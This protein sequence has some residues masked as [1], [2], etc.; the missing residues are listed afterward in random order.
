MN[1]VSKVAVLVCAVTL[2]VSP[3]WTQPSPPLSDEEIWAR[4]E[5]LQKELDELKALVNQRAASPI[6]KPAAPSPSPITVAAPSKFRFSGYLQARAFDDQTT[7]NAPKRTDQFNVRRVRLEFAGDLSQNVGGRLT[8]DVGGSTGVGSLRDAYVDVKTK[9]ATF[10]VGQWKFPFNYEMALSESEQMALEASLATQRLFPG[11]RERGAMVDV[12]LSKSLHAP[13]SLQVA[14][15][16]G[17]GPNQ[18]DNNQSKDVFAS[19]SYSTPKFQARLSGITGHFNFT[20][21]SGAGAPFRTTKRRVGLTLRTVQS[22]WDVHGQFI[23]GQGDFPTSGSAPTLTGTL[24]T[25]GSFNN[26]DVAGWYV[27]AARKLHA[28]PITLWG[29]FERF[30][31]NTDIGGDTIGIGAMG[32]FW[33]ATPQLRFTLGIYR[34]AFRTVP[35][36]TT[37][38]FQTQ[39]KF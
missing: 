27:M 13:L 7:T 37:L 12:D 32:G 30:D 11:S 10:R 19:L 16:N 36:K 8:F 22:G 39:V 2:T 15:F 26:N 23:R 6:D 24:G 28:K 21:T 25:T 38:G 29:R 3:C 20:P 33:D 18:S 34:K 9:A 14:L 4:I 5:Q 17:V 1:K 35:E 31:P